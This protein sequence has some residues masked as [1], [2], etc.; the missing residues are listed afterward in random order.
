MSTQN[1]TYKTDVEKETN[2]S[3]WN[4]GGCWAAFVIIVLGI[5]FFL[6]LAAA[7]GM[8]GGGSSTTP[9]EDTISRMA[10]S[11]PRPTST[12]RSTTP[13][14]AQD[15]WRVRRVSDGSYG[16]ELG[17]SRPG[18]GTSD[19][20]VAT[21]VGYNLSFMTSNGEVFLGRG[22]QQAIL[23]PN[24]YA[25][26]AGGTDWG[27]VVWE[28][29]PT[30]TNAL[31][32]MTVL[33]FQLAQQQVEWESCPNKP[34]TELLNHV[35]VITQDTNSPQHV[36]IT[37]WREFRRATGENQVLLIA[38]GDSF[39]GW[40]VGINTENDLCD[41]GGCYLQNAPT[42]AWGGGGVINSKWVGE[43]PPNAT[44]AIV[45]SPRGN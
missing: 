22:C 34:D 31:N 12:P 36:T 17:H 24:T 27:F 26:N 6:G 29:N 40:H 8:T 1:I 38:P 23:P 25:W 20:E 3:S 9:V 37:P 19:N 21:I 39:Y 43:I 42:W 33:S 32:E 5:A 11:T 16:P 45:V 14:T 15:N 44:P 13:T 7:G 18:V 2:G 4:W 28:I 30:T 35:M 41:G 10:V